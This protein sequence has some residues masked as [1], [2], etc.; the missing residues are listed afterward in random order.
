[1]ADL[2]STG[3]AGTDG[4]S[5]NQFDDTNWDNVTGMGVKP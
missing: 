5:L 3:F 2:Y 1:M 4:N